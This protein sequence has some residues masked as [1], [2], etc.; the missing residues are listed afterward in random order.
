MNYLSALKNA[1]FLGHFK[2]DLTEE[3]Q[4]DR[5][6]EATAIGFVDDVLAVLEVEVASRTDNQKKLVEGY[7]WLRTKWW[8]T[9]ISLHT[10][11]TLDKRRHDA[12]TKYKNEK[13]DDIFSSVRSIWYTCAHNH[14]RNEEAAA[15]VFTVKDNDFSVHV[16]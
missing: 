14:L 8:P 15:R 9:T 3:E 16:E 10:N 6:D 5:D 4:N 1:T 11:R 7:D 12:L 2:R 13:G